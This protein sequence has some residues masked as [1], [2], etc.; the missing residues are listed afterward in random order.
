MA[1][2]AGAT[3]RDA[4]EFMRGQILGELKVAM[5]LDGVLLGRRGLR[6]LARPQVDALSK[7]ASAGRK[8]EKVL[9]SMARV[10]ADKRMDGH[11]NFAEIYAGRR[12]DRQRSNVPSLGYRAPVS[13][14]SLT[15]DVSIGIQRYPFVPKMPPNNLG[16]FHWSEWG[17]GRSDGRRL[18]ARSWRAHMTSDCTAICHRD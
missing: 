3:N 13:V 11:S 18:D 10:A 4:Y 5:H 2:P 6:M 14:L 15:S 16:L 9:V 1:T 7:A 12:R 17:I 8:G